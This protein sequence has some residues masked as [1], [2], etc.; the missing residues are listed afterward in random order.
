MTDETSAPW[1]DADESQAWNGL[2]AVVQR[3][4][5]EIERDLRTNHDMLAVHYHILVSLSGAPEHTLRLSD[6]AHTANLS[7]SRLTHRLRVLVDRGDV[8]I[9]Q[10]P[11]DKRAKHAR[12]TEG[13]LQRLRTVAPAHVA[14][15]R[16]L[17]FDHLSPAQSRA[18]AGAL[19][20]IAAS[21]CDHPEYLNPQ[22]CPPVAAPT[23]G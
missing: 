11:D 5:P 17:I 23:D 22:H 8:E 19:A 4:F 13:G 1:L 12:L 6:L 2:L 14:T 18:L 10:H 21:L 16:R 20:P 15:V 7:Q 3:A 9:T